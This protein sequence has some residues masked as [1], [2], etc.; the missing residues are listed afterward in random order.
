[1]GDN[2]LYLKVGAP[3]GTPASGEKAVFVDTDGTIKQVDS[4]GTKSVVG[5]TDP[6]PYGYTSTGVQYSGTVIVAAGGAGNQVPVSSTSGRWGGTGAALGLGP[7]GPGDA[8][9]TTIYGDNFTPSNPLITFDKTNGALLTKRLQ[10]AKGAAVASAAPLVL[11]NDGNVFHVTGT[12]NFAGIV[13]TNWQAGAEI[14]LIFDGILTITHNSGA[15]GASAVKVFFKSGANLTTAVNST[16]R[17][18]YDGSIWY[19]V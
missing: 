5:A 18:V 10:Y 1:M 7:M 19:E 13:T 2:A 8:G 6:T 3:V 15:P 16:V 9:Q 14:I 12:T 11:G 17:L 4:T